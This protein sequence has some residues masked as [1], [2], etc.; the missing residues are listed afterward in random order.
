[1]KNWNQLIGETVV[2]DIDG[3]VLYIGRLTSINDE[4]INLEEVD[5]H[6]VDDSTTSRE[7]YIIDT[8]TLGIRANRKKASVRLERV[9]GVSRLQD[10]LEF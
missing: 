9:V 2:L 6:H 8:K 3:P 7:K 10:V 1:M 4:W 5:V